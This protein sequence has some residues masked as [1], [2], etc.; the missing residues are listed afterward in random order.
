MTRTTTTIAALVV[1]AIAVG[2][3]APA[4]AD[5]KGHGPDRMRGEPGFERQMEMR[6]EMRE[7]MRGEGRGGFL[8]LVCAPQGADRLE[9]ALLK[10][11]QRT[12]PA[13]GQVAL[14]D[15]LKTTALAAQSDFATAC[16]AAR[17]AEGDTADRDLVDRLTTGLAIDEARVAAMGKVLPAFE[18]FYD[19][20]SDEQK[21]A[22]TP[23][24]G[25]R[26]RR[27]F[28]MHRGAPDMTAPTAPESN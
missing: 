8:A 9:Q 20:L 5:D 21:Q 7:E 14:F 6:G 3:A 4:L 23:P 16:A 27:G 28:R 13:D 10:L 19:S 18:A 2:A 24:R 1:A 17:P 11:E 15:T 25:E 26:E 12:D 22:L